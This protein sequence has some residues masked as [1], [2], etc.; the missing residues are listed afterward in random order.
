MLAVDDGEDAAT[1]KDYLA[2]HPLAFP[3][4]LDTNSYAHAAFHA[5]GIPA[6]YVVNSG[7]MITLA[8]V[9]YNPRIAR[10]LNSVLAQR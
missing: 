6:V 9:G 7:G 5:G 1:V 2:Q 4:L 3:N 10:E 8:S